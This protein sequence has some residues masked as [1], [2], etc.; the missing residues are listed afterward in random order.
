MLH[1]KGK[2][3]EAVDFLKDHRKLYRG[4]LTKYDNL[5]ENLRR[6]VQLPSGKNLNRFVLVL[7]MDRDSSESNIKNLFSNSTRINSIQFYRDLSFT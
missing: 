2:T 4:D 5:V 3:Q 7:N 1:Q 6:Q